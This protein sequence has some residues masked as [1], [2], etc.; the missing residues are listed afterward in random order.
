MSTLVRF[1]VSKTFYRDE[2]VAIFPQL[3]YN[4]RLY[5]NSE[6]VCYA[7]IGQHSSCRKEWAYDKKHKLATPDQYK[8]LKK[9]L[10]DAGYIL[11]VC[12]N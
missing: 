5:G 4:K 9:E 1:I 2:V 11:K 8:D 7:H 12:K 6:L 10:K 3:K